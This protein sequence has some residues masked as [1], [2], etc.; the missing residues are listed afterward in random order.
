MFGPI[1]SAI[2]LGAVFAGEIGVGI[3]LEE[4]FED[5]VSKR[6]DAT[7]T[8][9]IM[10]RLKIKRRR[11]DPFYTTIHEVVTKPS[12]VGFNDKGFLLA[13]TAF[14]GRETVPI[15]SVVIRDETRDGDFKLPDC[16]TGLKILKL[17]RR[18]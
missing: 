3:Y 4:R 10:D 14:V 6:A 8:D 15:D 13:G 16:A 2:F 11:W 18:I 1:A 9:V 5:K 7:L 12:L 17:S